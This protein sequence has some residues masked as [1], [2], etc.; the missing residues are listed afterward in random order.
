MEPGEKGKKAKKKEKPREP[1]EN[2]TKEQKI[3]QKGDDPPAKT[4]PKEKH[5][6][7]EGSKIEIKSH[8][9]LKKY[10]GQQW[11]GHCKWFNV[12]RGF[13]FLVPDDKEDADV[14][15]HQVDCN[16]IINFKF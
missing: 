7:E 11:T 1:S 6:S 14:F 15:V 13:G 3:E 5:K 12:T 2:T 16:F 9:E 8:E 4:E 10:I